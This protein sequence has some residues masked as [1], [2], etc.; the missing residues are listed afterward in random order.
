MEINL[1]SGSI[2][3]LPPT[4]GKYPL[5]IIYGGVAY[6]TPQ[7]MK[8]QLD[9]DYQNKA[10]LLLVD[11]KDNFSRVLVKGKSEIQKNGYSI[12]NT[13]LT[14]FSAGGYDVGQNF[15]TTYKLIGFIDP[16]LESSFLNLPFGSN[17]RMVY[18]DANWTAYPAIKSLQ[19]KVAQKIKDNSGEAI[20]VNLQHDKIPKY[21]FDRYKNDFFTIETPSSQSVPSLL[22]FGLLLIATSV[23]ISAH[24]LI[25]TP[26]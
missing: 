1:G 15:D 8:K 11:Y 22:I 16:S 18:N 6:A 4:K 23:A 9:S 19:P 26:E 5:I 2:I 21:F 20:K 7:W 13:S 3:S 10:I 17:V 24:Y 14:G 25:K 12:E